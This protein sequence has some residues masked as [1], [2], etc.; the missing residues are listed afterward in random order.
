MT[1]SFFDVPRTTATTTEGDVTLPIF[2]FDVSALLAVF[3]VHTVDVEAQ[4]FAAELR[5]MRLPGGRTPLVLAWFEYRA[6]TIGSYNEVAVAVGCYHRTERRQPS[7]LIDALLPAV[8]RG[9][10]FHV[11]DLP[12]TTPAACA[13]G[14]ELWGYPKF[15]TEIPLSFGRARFEG[16]VLEP[17]TASPLVR[18]AG[19]WGAGPVVPAFD[20]VLFSR[21]QERSLK[22]TV[23]IDARMR[24]L[25][26]RH[27]KLQVGASEHPMAQ[28]LRRLGL[29]GASPLLVQQA[30]SF[31]SRLNR[32][33]ELG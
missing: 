13:A 29:H 10:G 3:S 26:P 24:T 1:P 2:Y 12:V 8:R 7:V 23:D 15:V 32:G 22:T 20:W 30:L 27:M 6:T 11:L 18:L 31:R 5:P 17:G 33:S 4:L 19:G 28:R 14:R 25:R 21:R 16:A 9:G